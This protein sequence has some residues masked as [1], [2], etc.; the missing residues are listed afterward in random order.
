M[1]RRAIVHPPWL[2]RMLIGWGLKSLHLHGNGWY[3]INPMLKD[4][5][6][7]GRPPGELFELGSEDYRALDEAI[8]ALPA[9]QR[10][11]I[12]RAYKPWT[13]A[14]LDAVYLCG[15]STW[16]ERLKAAALTLQTVMRR[17]G[18]YLPSESAM[19]F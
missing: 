16:C 11:A 10:D 15:T 17:D 14:A 18:V 19:V 4:G 7:T 6:P 13:A 9:V 2:D 1:S 5:I 8:N 3:S 12:T